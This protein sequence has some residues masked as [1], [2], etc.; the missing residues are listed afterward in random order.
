MDF[1]P[2]KISNADNQAILTRCAALGLSLAQVQRLAGVDNSLQ[3]LAWI[4]GLDSVTLTPLKPRRWMEMAASTSS[5]SYRVVLTPEILLEVLTTGTVPPAYASTLLHF[6]EEAP[7]QVVVMSVEQAAQQSGV[8]I[9][10]IWHHV[11]Q[12]GAAW[13]S[14]RLRSIGA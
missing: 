8:A 2:I 1:A 9:E 5:V 7:I 10:Q 13:A 14:T 6:L 3:A 12:I 4:L 11:D